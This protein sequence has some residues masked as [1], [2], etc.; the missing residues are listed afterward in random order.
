MDAYVKPLH[1]KD[2]H[3]SYSNHSH[4]IPVKLPL[5]TKGSE[6]QSKCIEILKEQMCEEMF[7]VEFD[8]DNAEVMRQC[9]ENGVNL[10]IVN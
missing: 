9:E 5:N 4:S 3:N 8:L 1:L 6:N 10:R 7:C 2:F